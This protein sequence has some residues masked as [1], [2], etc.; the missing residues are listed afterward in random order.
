MIQNVK[1]YQV[2]YSMRLHTSSV[3]TGIVILVQ[4]HNYGRRVTIM[5]VRELEANLFG[6]A[7]FSQGWQVQTV[8]MGVAYSSK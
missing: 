2:L 8:S 5:L 3:P 4:I 7:C 1:T 6:L